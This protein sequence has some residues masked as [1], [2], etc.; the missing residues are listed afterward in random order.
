LIQPLIKRLEESPKFK[1]KVLEMPTTFE[2]AYETVK[3]YL[4]IYGKPDM[5]FCNFDRVEM[6]GACL[7]F[8][9]SRVPIAQY[10]AGDIS[11][12]GETF[13]D[14]I[15]F[16]ITLCSD[17]QFCNSAKSFTHCLR[18]LRLVGKPVEHCYHVGSL[19]FDDVELDYTIVPDEPFDLILYN[20]LPAKPDLMED[21]LRQ[22]EELLGDRLAIWIFPNEDEGR[23]KVIAK[24]KELEAEG[25]VKGLNTVPRPQFLALMEKAE[26]VIGNS[27]SFYMELPYFYKTHIRNGA[28]NRNRERVKVVP[29]ASERMVKILEKFFLSSHC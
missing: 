12:E 13:D 29:G 23:E 9:F 4:R 26:R 20:P 6:L 22:I 2:G 25:K 3:E 1:L 14:Y 10:H 19:A 17:I 7:A 8:Y 5:A 11:G 24:I 16:M 18:F 27:S 15:R 28:R 21:E